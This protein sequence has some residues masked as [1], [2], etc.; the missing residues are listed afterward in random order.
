MTEQ[1]PGEFGNSAEEGQN[2]RL[3][4]LS[5][6]NTEGTGP[7]FSTPVT[8]RQKSVSAPATPLGLGQAPDA[9][10]AQPQ[11]DDVDHDDEGHVHTADAGDAADSDFTL[12]PSNIPTVQQGA[13]SPTSE[14]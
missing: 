8:G 14:D 7:L 10:F 5:M 4:R 3:S 13:Q 12:V 6:R 2:F 11:P 9:A 1:E